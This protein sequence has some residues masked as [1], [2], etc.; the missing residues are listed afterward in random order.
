MSFRSPKRE[1]NK[2]KRDFEGK[3]EGKR[4]EG[5]E[6]KKSEIEPKQKTRRK[7]KKI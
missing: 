4:E 5:S 2:V 6:K 7:E 3:E 1:K